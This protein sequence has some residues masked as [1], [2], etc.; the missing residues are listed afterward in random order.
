M[1]QH[2]FLYVLAAIMIVVPSLI[3]R[4]LKNLPFF[5]GEYSYYYLLKLGISDFFA[6]KFAVILMGILSVFI[7]YLLLKK[8]KIE[9][10]FVYVASF[11]F[12]VSIPF[13]YTISRFT[14]HT[15][16]VFL[17]LF[18]IYILA[19]GKKWSVFVS[20][21][22][23]VLSSVFGIY[24]VASVAIFIVYSLI[25]RKNVYYAFF[26]SAVT[27]VLSELLFDG[28]TGQNFE[29]TQSVLQSFVTDFGALYGISAM[30]WVLALFGFFMTWKAKSK[31]FPIYAVTLLFGFL[32][33]K[34]VFFLIYLNLFVVLY[35]AFFLRSLLF[36]KW[37]LK[38]C[39][40]FIQI[41]I[42]CSLLFTGVYYANRASVGEPTLEMVESLEFLSSEDKGI[43][44][45]HP[46][47]GNYI[48]YF[49][50]N[51]VFTGRSKD[52]RDFL[53]IFYAT[54]IADLFVKLKQYDI[55]YIWIDAEMKEGQVWVDS[56]YGLLSLLQNKVYFS[57]IYEEGDIEIWIVK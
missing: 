43:V 51:E 55:K 56:D 31:F 19:L 17:I 10:N 47:N 50:G 41:V 22:I 2:Y 27:L 24:S 12:A 44:L 11:L 5:S 23:L 14:P 53:E 57:K 21:A 20:G 32:S 39:G 49:S 3:L 29:I 42:V 8:L 45:S 34:Y 52:K 1:R 28:F 36:R 26:F 15:L 4:P 30:A 54:S 25:V 6:V 18:S 35:S 7:F 48:K 9:K 38:I 40:V 37:D 13:I 16:L 33:T 46:E